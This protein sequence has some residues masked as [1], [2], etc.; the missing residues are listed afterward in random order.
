MILEITSKN[1][2]VEEGLKKIVA[3]N[4]DD[5]M[6]AGFVCNA[7]KVS[8]GVY[9]LE[10]AFGNPMAEAGMTNPLG[11]RLMIRSIKKQFRKFAED[12]EVRKVK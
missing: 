3:H 4:K 6:K 9:H 7:A 12:V 2:L 10:F 8:E 11:M 1:P 5:F